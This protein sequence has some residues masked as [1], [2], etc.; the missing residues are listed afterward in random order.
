MNFSLILEINFH[1][2][3]IIDLRRIEGRRAREPLYFRITI[4][5][6]ID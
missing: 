3:N 4:S 6:K 1:L 2:V 5:G